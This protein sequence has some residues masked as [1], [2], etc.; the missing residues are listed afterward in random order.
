MSDIIEQENEV[1]KEMG[2]INHS[3]VQAKITGM[4]LNDERFTPAVELSLDISQIDLSQFGLKAKEE[5][6]PDICL[7]QGRRELSNPDDVLKMTEMPLLAIEV[8][9][10]KQTIDDILAKFK[11]YFALGIKSCWLVTPAIRAIAIY[12]QA[13]NFKTFGMNDTEVIDEIMDIHLPIQK[14]FGW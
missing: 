2:S 10:P 12:S 11:A 14:V 8:L 13:S 9:S 6:K 5:L 1:L 4:L 7:Y 3:I